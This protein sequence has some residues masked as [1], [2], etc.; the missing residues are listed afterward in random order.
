[1]NSTK[2]NITD[3]AA[4]FVF[5]LLKS[6]LSPNY[7]YHN[8]T[9]TCE[10]VEAVKKIGGKLGLSES[11]LEPAIIAAWFHDTGFTE[12]SSNHEDTGIRYAREFLLTHGYPESKTEVVAGCINATRYPQSPSN[13]LEEIICDADLSYLGT[14]EFG[15]K[16]DLLRIEWEKSEGKIYSEV[17]WLKVNTD[18]LTT[19]KYFTA[20]A[21][22]SWDEKKSSNLVKLQKR[23]RK[24]QSVEKN[25][26]IER[27][28]ME[29]EMQ[30]LESGANSSEKIDSYKFESLLAA[31]SSQQI[32]ASEISGKAN[33]LMLSSVVILTGAIFAAP[34]QISEMPQLGLASLIAAI[35]SSISLI[36][37]VLSAFPSQKSGTLTKEE[38]QKGRASVL[39]SDDFQSTDEGEYGKAIHAAFEDT[40]LLS[41]MLS[42][43]L[44]DTGRKLGKKEGLLRSAY[45]L[46]ITGCVISCISY[47]WSAVKFKQG[48]NGLFD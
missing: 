34:F 3:S 31:I 43:Q 47:I 14:K 29:F 28:R 23:L 25:E 13:L 46:F 36:L 2:A 10:V 6:K 20:Y 11:E 32:R 27:E 24:L 9:H 48:L 26:S 8:Y 12:S 42:K 5:D 18:F 15:Y 40:V 19:H 7:V 16:S 1:M 4:D 41:A 30:K 38:V 17:E 22:K 21:K 39:N 37:A 44:F 35:T 33:F 45:I